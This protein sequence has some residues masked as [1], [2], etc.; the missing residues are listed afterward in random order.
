MKLYAYCWANGVIDFGSELPDGALSIV[1]GPA[2]KVRSVVSVVARHAKDNETLLVPGIP[3]A[4][5]EHAK[6]DSLLAFCNQVEK[7]M[8]A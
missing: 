4:A 1:K 5:N 6:M 2:A 8:K 3:E 7:R